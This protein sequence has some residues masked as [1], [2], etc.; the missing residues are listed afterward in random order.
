MTTTSKSDM[1][2]SLKLA[3][4]ERGAG[5]EIH[6]EPPRILQGFLD[7][8][9]EGDR[10]LAVDNAM[11][12]AERQIHHRADHD[13]T[14]D[15]HRAFLNLV[16][17]KNAGLRR[18]QNGR[19]HERSV[20]PAIRDSE[21]AALHVIERQLAVARLLPEFRNPLLDPGKAHSVGIAYHRDHEA[22]LGADS[23]A[24]MRIFLVD[25]LFALDLGIDRRD[26]GKRMAAGFHE[27]GHE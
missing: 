7:A 3:G 21:G 24:D 27:E 11:I 4:Q 17:S 26:L 13:L 15:D 16:H 9:E 1:G 8:D 25:D 12:V 5:S 14:A 2:Y 6:Q 23:D 20:D 10:F 19:G 22:L 18:V